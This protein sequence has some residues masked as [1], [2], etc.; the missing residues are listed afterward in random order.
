M[1]KHI[2]VPIFI[3]HIGCPNACV[4]CNQKAIS[5]RMGFDKSRV[6]AELDAAFAT[7]DGGVP[8]QIA[9]F[10]GSFTG[11]AREDMLELLAIAGE[12]VDAGKCESVRISTRPDYISDEILDILKRNHVSAIELG[13]QSTDDSV[14]TAS[15]RGHTAAYSFRA[16]A[17]IK[18]YGFTFIGQ[19]MVGLPGA[20]PES[21][22]QTALDI[23]RMGAD[24]A[25][26]YPAVVFRETALADMTLRGD[27][28]P[29]TESSSVFRAENALSV[30]MEYGIPVIRIGLQSGEMLETGEGVLAGGYHPAVG[31]LAY[32]LYFKNRVEA[33]LQ[34]EE[35]KRKTLVVR[36]N[37]SDVSKAIGQRGANRSYFIKTYALAGFKVLP[38]GAIPKN[39]CEISLQPTIK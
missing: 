21:E 24:G 2:N 10:G 37:P 18:A 9:Y 33:L 15:G 34:K 14:L 23:V 13:I 8:V 4:F 35:T 25:R 12:Y 29:L 17:R 5:G 38:D 31:E 26:I 11:I 36:V 1:K 22:K 19:M 27:Y 3:P 28:E 7:I 20:T 39:G 32:A 6:R 30:F 16:A